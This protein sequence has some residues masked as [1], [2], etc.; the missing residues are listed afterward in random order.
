M[1]KV[2]L[3][4]DLT[5]YS[6]ICLLTLLLHNYIRLSAFFPGKPGQVS[7][8][9]VNHSAFYGSKRRWGG[10]G[11]NWTICKSFAPRPRQITTPVPHHSVFYRP[12]NLPAAQPTAAKHF[13]TSAVC[14]SKK[15]C[16][17]NFHMYV[18]KHKYVYKQ[19]I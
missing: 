13:H 9:K 16:Y 7:T 14:S 10:S 8:K 11:I 18:I 19:K 15:G 6:H 5:N 12:D 2:I 1:R 3:A 4:F 17:T